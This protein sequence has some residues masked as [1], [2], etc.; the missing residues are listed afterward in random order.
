MK[1]IFSLV[2]MLCFAGLLSAQNAPAAPKKEIKTATAD[3]EKPV[4]KDAKEVRTKIKKETKV[5]DPVQLNDAKGDVKTTKKVVK[6]VK[7]E[8]AR[9]P[10]Q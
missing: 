6:K 9:N 5:M 4:L 3:V 1:S 10:K 7:G 2:V 8:T